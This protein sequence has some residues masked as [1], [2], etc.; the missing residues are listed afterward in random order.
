MATIEK[1]IPIPPTVVRKGEILPLAQ[2]EI[3]DSVYV[4]DLVG[5]YG[6][7]RVRLAK[8]HRRGVKR[9]VSRREENGTRVW[10]TK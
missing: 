5:S 3:G 10:R 1:N 8:E 4:D 7:L 9:F 2:L 6:A